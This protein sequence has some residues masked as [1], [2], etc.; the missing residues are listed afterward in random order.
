MGVKMWQVDK[1]VAQAMFDDRA[2]LGVTLRGLPVPAPSRLEFVNRGKA[3][4]SRS[5]LDR[6][7]AALAY[8]RDLV[9]RWFYGLGRSSACESVST[10]IAPTSRSG[11][12]QETV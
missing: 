8:R 12:S 9:C 1:H 7:L 11:C 3:V 6:R 2:D 4:L 10:W 5:S